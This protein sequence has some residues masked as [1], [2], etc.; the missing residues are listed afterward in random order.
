M[1]IAT[2][3]RSTR[4]GCA[5]PTG[6]PSSP[7][8]ATSSSRQPSRRSSPASPRRS[9]AGSGSTSP[10]C[11]GRSGARV[12]SRP[13]PTSRRRCGRGRGSLAVQAGMEAVVALSPTG[14]GPGEAEPQPDRRRAGR[15]PV[16]AG[17]GAAR[18][19]LRRGAA[20]H[21]DLASLFHT[22][23]TTGTPK[24]A[25]HTHANEVSD[26]WMIAA[27]GLLREGTVVAGA[28][29][30]PCQRTARHRPGPTVPGPRV[31]WAG[32]LG[33]RDQAL[34]ARFWKLVERYGVTTMSAV[35]TVYLRPRRMPGRRGHQQPPLRRRRRLATA[36]GGP[37]RL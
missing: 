5:G 2:P 21:T 27:N 12:L 34:Y 1:C 7:P 6:S 25:A 31:I 10:S 32:P 13:V 37:G 4:S 36:A 18:G 8:T 11:C 15:P 30:V 14:V 24:L 20:S 23:G 16:R 17:G 33:Y 28:A 35:P 29:A 9:T 3:T 22:G 19:R 26:A